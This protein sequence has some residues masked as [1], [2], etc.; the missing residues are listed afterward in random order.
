MTDEQISK[1]IARAAEDETVELDLSWREI[2]SLPPTIACLTKLRKLSLRSNWLR[3]LPP[4]L[5]Q[6]PNLK[7][8]DVA[9]NLL[10]GDVPAPIMEMSQLEELD[11]GDTILE[12][13]P[14][15][16]AGLRSLR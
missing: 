4:E 3:E 5:A 15:G 8:L 16:F 9:D 10:D 14:E 6:L 2:V 1:L 13:L 7:S 12:T 11:L